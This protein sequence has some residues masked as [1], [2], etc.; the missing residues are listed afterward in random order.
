MILLNGNVLPEQSHIL[1]RGLLFGDGV[2]ETIK[3]RNSKILFWEEHYFRLM[4]AMRICRMEI[5]MVFTMEH[6]ASEILTLLQSNALT[7]ARVRVTVF[8]NG[9]GYYMPESRE[10]SYLITAKYLAADYVYDAAFF[11][12]DLYKDYAVPAQLLSTIKTTNKMVNILAGIYAAENNLNSCLLLNEKRHVVEAIE[13]NIFVFM[14]N[15]L[16]T[17]PVSE[18]CLNGIMRKQIIEIAKSEG[19][20]VKEMALEVFELQ[21]ASEMFIT[22]VIIGIKP[23]TQ[24]RKKEYHFAV[25]KR[26]AEKLQE[27][28][29]LI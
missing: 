11:E 12:V 10:V 15:Q 17:P 8:R 27:R 7:D 20:V 13:G 29:N 6:L 2:F 25:S 3:V 1:N 5:P 14:D 28:T 4:A 16:L 23:I 19:I 22:N 24:Y 18:G 9:L 26:L 21:N